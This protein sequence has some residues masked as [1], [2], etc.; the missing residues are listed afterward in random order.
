LLLHEDGG[1]L[2]LGQ[3]LSFREILTEAFAPEHLPR[4]RFYLLFIH[5]AEKEEGYLYDFFRE[6]QQPERPPAFFDATRNER[7]VLI[8]FQEMKK[9]SLGEFLARCVL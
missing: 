4:I 3:Y 2:G 6:R 8:P 5:E 7:R 1:S 9:I